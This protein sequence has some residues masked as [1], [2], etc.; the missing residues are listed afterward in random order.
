MA[1]RVWTELDGSGRP[2]MKVGPHKGK[3]VD[4]VPER[5][6]RWVLDSAELRP[7]HE[8]EVELREA[9]CEVVGGAS[10]RAG[11]AE[12]STVAVGHWSFAVPPEVT[13]AFDA[14]MER[15]RQLFPSDAQAFEALL[16]NSALTPLES[17]A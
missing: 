7:G 13:Q 2:R 4:E 11:T 16:A 3:D 14:E 17:L 8:E 6:L 12:W 9:A 1:G 10:Q 15:L 5:H